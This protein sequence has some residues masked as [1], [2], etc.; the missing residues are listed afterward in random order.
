[1]MGKSFT[2]MASTAIFPIPFHSKIVSMIV[3]PPISPPM[4]MP[5]IVM[6]ESRELGRICWKMICRLGNPRARPPLR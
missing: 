5:N 2:A 1:M 3:A 6:T 4:D